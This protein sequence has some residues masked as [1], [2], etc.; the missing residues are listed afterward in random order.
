MRRMFAVTAFVA[1][2]F[3]CSVASSAEIN[4]KIDIPN[5]GNGEYLL[6]PGAPRGFSSIT[7]FQKDPSVPL[8]GTIT[9]WSGNYSMTLDL[10]T[11]RSIFMIGVVPSMRI[12]IDGVEPQADFNIVLR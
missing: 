6:I 2:T 11:E 3:V 1:M 10:A 4:A 5:P 7:V 8:V 12:V 9:A